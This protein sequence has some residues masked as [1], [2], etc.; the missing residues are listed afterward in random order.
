MQ[1]TDYGNPVTLMADFPSSKLVKNLPYTVKN[2]VEL[3]DVP[4]RINSL[5]MKNYNSHVEILFSYT[6]VL[7]FQFYYRMR[8][9]DIRTV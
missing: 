5:M 6:H 8:K 7:F 1:E 2:A 3:L 4:P 9:F